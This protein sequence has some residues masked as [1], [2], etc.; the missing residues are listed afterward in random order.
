MDFIVRVAV[1][2]LEEMENF[3]HKEE[4]LDPCVLNDIVHGE[5]VLMRDYHVCVL[6][7]DYLQVLV[8]IHE[9]RCILIQ[10]LV[11]LELVRTDDFSHLPVEHSGCLVVN[12]I[13][14]CVSFVIHL[15]E[16]SGIIDI[17]VKSN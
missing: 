10:N 5:V 11:V 16:Q 1:V 6:S 12:L 14:D 2:N 8:K 7:R 15:D 9:H 4:V 13:I 17:N 3:I